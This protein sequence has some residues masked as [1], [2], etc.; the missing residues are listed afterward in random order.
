M[1]WETELITLYFLVCEN[2]DDIFCSTLRFSPNDSPNFTDEELMTIYLYCTKEGYFT[3]KRMHTYVQ[4][5]LLSWFPNLPSYQAF[6]YRLNN[7]E[8]A[9]GNLCN[10]LIGLMPSLT[11]YY[12]S[13]IKE[14][15]TD[16][17]PIILRKGNGSEKAKVAT[18]IANKGYCS[19][20][21]LYYHGLKLHLLAW[22][23]PYH[24][25][26][27]ASIVLSPSAD[28]DASVFY[29]QHLQ[30]HSHCVV[31]ADKIYDQPNNIK[32][33]KSQ[34]D[35]E[36]CPIRKDQKGQIYRDSFK[37]YLNTMISRVRQPI[38]AAFNWLIQH[39]DIQNASKCRSTKGTLLHIFAK[40]ATA[41]CIYLFFNS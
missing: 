4:R 22:V 30:M 10:Y 39:T 36:V 11:A 18:A 25:P 12:P 3:K 34:Y 41:L 24:I 6:N 31:Y 9:F 5:H 14:G 38:E 28:N 13:G 21:N 32:Y 19:T 37:S 33:A 26:Q 2:S 35:V 1:D 20:K 23:V 8:A 27:P 29:N 15:I 7:L 17:L 16:S 40:M